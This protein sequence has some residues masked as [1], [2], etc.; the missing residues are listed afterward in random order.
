MAAKIQFGFKT[1]KIDAIELEA[2]YGEKS[3]IPILY[4]ISSIQFSV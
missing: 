2:S 4:K 1:L 3:I